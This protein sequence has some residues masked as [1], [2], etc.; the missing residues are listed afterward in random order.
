MQ[1]KEIISDNTYCNLHK[2][3]N[4]YTSAAIATDRIIPGSIFITVI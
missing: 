1:R 4:N 3:C 2:K